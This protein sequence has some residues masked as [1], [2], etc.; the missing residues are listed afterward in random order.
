MFFIK[1]MQKIMIVFMA[2]VLLSFVFPTFNTNAGPLDGFN[3]QYKVDDSTG[4]ASFGANATGEVK[5]MID[6]ETFTNKTFSTL[7]KVIFGIFGVCSLTMVVL[8]II[9][10]IKLGTAAGNPQERA[11]ATRSLLY[12]G[13]ATALLGAVTL[14]VG[15]S[16]N[17]LK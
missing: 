7:Q 2:I 17:L 6:D 3:F 13:I 9:N 14:F 1:K 5:N 15:F 10:F 8:F 11:Q 4:Q 12:L 16:T